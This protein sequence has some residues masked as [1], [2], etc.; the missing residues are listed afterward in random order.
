MKHLIIIYSLLAI[1]L[2]EPL[3]EQQSSEQ[4][5]ERQAEQNS[6]VRVTSNGV[7]VDVNVGFDEKT[8]DDEKIKKVTKLISEFDS[9]FGEELALELGSLSEQDKAKLVKKLDQG[10]SFR[11]EIDAVPTGA[12]LIALP[13]VILIFGGPLFLVI[14]LLAFGHRKRKQKMELVE[15]YIKHDRDIP[16]HV[17]NGLDSGGS[18]SSLKSGLT[19]TAVGLGVV[20]ALGASGAEEAVGFG[21]IPMFL[22]IARLIFWSLVE[23]KNESKAQVETD[24]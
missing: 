8:S 2:K 12:V 18:A 10:F 19:L 23:R 22:G 4:N 3:T 7:K 1:G 5:S 17:I 21:L 14:A 13:A 9:D 6:G 11:N 16:E 15:L 24:S 20:A